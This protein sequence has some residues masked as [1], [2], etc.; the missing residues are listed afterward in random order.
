MVTQRAPYD[1]LLNLEVL[2]AAC[3]LA[4]QIYHWRGEAFNAPSDWTVLTAA[5]RQYYINKCIALLESL[6]PP[7]GE[8]VAFPSEPRL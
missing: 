4:P 7:T 8:L 1:P 2:S 5:A 3:Q 6:R